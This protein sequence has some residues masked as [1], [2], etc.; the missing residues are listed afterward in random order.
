MRNN[1]NKKYTSVKFIK[2][3]CPIH[4][5]DHN[6]RVSSF[7]FTLLIN[8]FKQ[9]LIIELYEV[10]MLQKILEQL[11]LNIFFKMYFCVYIISCLFF[12]IYLH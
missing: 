11:Q 4:L 9:A 12:C 8:C 1:N 2:N 7:T 10:K 3:S 6:R 5:T